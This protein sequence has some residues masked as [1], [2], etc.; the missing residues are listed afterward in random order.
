MARKFKTNIDLDSNQIQNA[1]LDG[2][3]LNDALDANS[4]KITGLANATAS[5]DAVHFGQVGALGFKDTIDSASLIDDG[6]IT[7][8]KLATAVQDKLNAN[9]AKNKLDATAAPG[10][11]DDTTEGYSVGSFWID[12]TGDEAYR[13][14]DATDGAAVWINTTLTTSELGALALKDTIDSSALIDNGVVTYAKIQNT[15]GTNVILGRETAGAGVIEEITCTSFARSILDDANE[16]AFKATV[17]L[18]IGTDVQAYDA[19]LAAIAGL[20]SA[21]NK[22]PM[23]SG[24]GTATVI[25]LLDEDDFSSDSATG[26]PTQQSAKAYVDGLVSGFASKYTADFNNTTDWAGSGP[27]TL[28][29][30]AAT[31]GLGATKA[32]MVQVFE[33]G[34]PN[35]NVEA[36]YTVADSG[37]VVITIDSAKFAG[38]YVI[39]G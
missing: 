30:S 11:N 33:D 24:A 22:I 7:E 4:Q 26:V 32:L 38:H 16:A 19:E 36:S 39:I 3:S 9:T 34:T 8:A 23:F 35:S 31:H 28:T 6:V 29:I 1:V 27:Y 2:A 15:S 18:E 14:V 13:C 25:D 21:A 20:T 12:V 17:N 10:V 5:G 37:E